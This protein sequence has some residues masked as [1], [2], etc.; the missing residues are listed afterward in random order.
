LGFVYPAAAQTQQDAQP[1]L[2]EV[3]KQKPV[4][5]AAKV[6]TDDDMPQKPAEPPPAEAAAADKSKDAAA[7]KQAAA[8]PPA[9]PDSTKAPDGTVLDTP[10]RRVDLAKASEAASKTKIDDLKKRRDAATTDAEVADLDAQLQ[11][12]QNYLAMYT[13]AREK[14]EQEAAAAKRDKQQAAPAPTPPPQPSGSTS[15]Q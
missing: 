12:E 8:A 9:R 11:R 6:V 10:E 15:P 4:K 14:A 1:S 13:A 3:A 2:G 5:K 7:T